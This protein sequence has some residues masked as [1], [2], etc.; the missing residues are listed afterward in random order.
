M[1]KVE[2]IN[3]DIDFKELTEKLGLKGEIT[4]ISTSRPEIG[5]DDMAKKCIVR[6]VLVVKTPIP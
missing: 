3:Y 6:I 5:D 4:Y 1:N 2:T